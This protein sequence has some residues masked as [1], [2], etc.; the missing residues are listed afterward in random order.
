MQHDEDGT[1]DWQPEFDPAA[2][3]ALIGKYVLVGITVED[4][5]GAWRR[6]EQ[7]HGHIVRAEQGGIDLALCGRGAGETKLLPPVTNLFA[8]ASKGVYTLRSTG[9]QVVDPDYTVQWLVV[10][11]DA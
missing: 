4:R 1:S 3:A 10:E 7:Y 6:E 11:S 5:R 8:P 9:E 2:A